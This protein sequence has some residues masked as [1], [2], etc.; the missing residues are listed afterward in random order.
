MILGFLRPGSL[1]EASSRILED[2][3]GTIFGFLAFFNTLAETGSCCKGL[4]RHPVASPQVDEAGVER[5]ASS[6]YTRQAW[7]TAR[8][9]GARLEAKFKSLKA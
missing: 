7:V 6:I 9:Q 3:G 8:A 2:E 4:C 5:R 1:Q